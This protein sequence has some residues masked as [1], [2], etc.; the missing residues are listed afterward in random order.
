M[1]NTPGSGGRKKTT[2]SG[3]AGVKKDQKVNTSGPVGRKDGYSQG[4]PGSSG[5]SNRTTSRASGSGLLSLL[6][7]SGGLK[8]LILIAVAIIVLLF[9]FRVCTGGCSGRTDDSYSLFDLLFGGY[10]DDYYTDSSS[11][12][13]TSSSSSS[14]GT[15]FN[16]ESLLDLFLSD[17]YD[18]TDE[19]AA[20]SISSTT[21]T[22][23]VNTTVS[24][25][26]R[27]KYTSIVGGGKD[28]I[29]IMV[30]MC[31]TDLEA[32][33][34]MGT[35]DLNEMLH[36]TL[37]DDRINL[38][39]ETGGTKRWN[40]SVIT[41]GTNQ[42]WRVTSKGLVSLEK[43][44]GRKS[45]VDP[46]TLSDF[47][48]YCKKN[49]PANR[50]CLIFWDHGGG[51][52]S[53]YGYDPYFSGSMT[54]DKISSALKAGGVQFDFIGFDAC[55]MATLETALVCEPYAD[56]L[57]ASEESEPGCGWY[58][59]TWLTQLSKNTSI[60]TV[61]L[62]Q[63]I[64]DDF[65]NVCKKNYPGCNTTLSVVDLAEFSGTIPES[66]ASFSQSVNTL[67]DEKE[68]DTMLRTYLNQKNDPPL[69]IAVKKNRRKKK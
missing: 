28:E 13:S 62:S 32:E 55:L 4:N 49:Y 52:L 1:N 64:I 25:K 11:S 18:T 53:G 6:L 9:L 7:G 47:I 46:N 56:Y 65:N 61:S 44:L 16:T 37:D 19:T 54:L 36:A 57:L 66:F 15:S 68:Y 43:N 42:R 59:T 45:M 2:A 29:T 51:S 63:T 23:T 12:G 34:G 31:G 27:E 3:S 24:N 5:G 41:S 48:Q 10:T 22:T 33:N 60:D 17:S 8:K 67:L 21:S 20:E 50:Y 69:M 14:S 35:A 40:N 58:Y 38:I 26:A 30:Y 39:V